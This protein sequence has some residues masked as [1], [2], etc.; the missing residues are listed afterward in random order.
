MSFIF[1]EE[2]QFILDH[3][4]DPMQV[5]AGAGSGKTRVL[6]ERYY[7]LLWQGVRVNNILAVTFTRKAA[8]EMVDRIRKRII[9]DEKLRPEVKD[10]LQEEL[11]FAFIGTIHS[12]CARL[13]RENP[14]E[15]GVDPH[16]RLIDEVEAYKLKM[17]I[18][19][20]SVYEMLEKNNPYLRKYVKFFGIKGLLDDLYNFLAATSSRGVKIEEL[21]L[22]T[23]M[24][25]T[26]TKNRLPDLVEKMEK[27]L[28]DMKRAAEQLKQGAATRNKIENLA[29]V[30]PQYLP[31]LDRIKT[32][33]GYDA[34]VYAACEKL[35]EYRLDARGNVKESVNSF[36]ESLSELKATLWE[37]KYFP[38]IEKVFLPLALEIRNQIVEEK[39][40]RNLLEF[41]DLEEKT[42]SMLLN[43]PDILEKYRKQF[44]F[45]MVDEFQDT[46]YRQT[47]IFRLLSDDFKRNI[48]TVGDPKQSIYRFRGA[49]VELFGRVGEKMGES[50]INAGL[51]RNYRTLSP[52][53]EFINHFFGIVM[54]DEKIPF[55]PLLPER[56]FTD[57]RRTMVYLT[58]ICD[59]KKMKKE[60]I[61]PYLI[62]RIIHNITNDKSLL[63][64][65]EKSGVMRNISYGDITLLFRTTA[66]MHIFARIFK[67]YGI[68]CHVVGSRDFFIAEE[69]EAMLKL[70]QAV[71]DREDEIAL[72]GAL[73]SFFFRVEN[74][75]LWL[76]KNRGQGLTLRESLQ[77]IEGLPLNEEEKQKLIWAEEVLSWAEKLKNRLAPAEL[78]RLL[79]E[80]TKGAFVPLRYSGTAQK[81]ANINKLVDIAF[82][83]EEKGI[84]S[85]KDFL[86][87]VEEAKNREI[88]EKQA[89]AE[90]EG[91]NRVKL[92]TVHQSKGLE[93]P[94]VIVPELERGF[95]EDDLRQNILVRDED[96]VFLKLSS[97]E[98]SR[99]E[100]K[101]ST[102][103]RAEL[104]EK[105]DSLSEYK[106]LLYVALTRSR[107]LLILTGIGKFRDDGTLSIPG[108]D[109]DPASWLDFLSMTYGDSETGILANDYFE[110]YV[111]DIFDIPQ[112]TKTASGQQPLI[113]PALPIKAVSNKDFI[114]LHFDYLSPTRM[115]E[116]DYCPQSAYLVY[117]EKINLAVLKEEKGLSSTSLGNIVHYLAEKT[118]S[119]ETAE[120][121]TAA[122]EDL[123]EE[124]K[125]EALKL[126]ENYLA[127]EEV[128]AIRENYAYLREVPFLM[129][130]DENCILRGFI[131]GLGIDDRKAC[132]IDL[133]TGQKREVYDVQ[134]AAYGKAVEKIMPGKEITKFIFYLKTG[135][136]VEVRDGSEIESVKTVSLY[137][138]K[139][140]KCT[141]C[142]FKILCFPEKGR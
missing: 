30:F 80:K 8:G 48:F 65:D 77:K 51:N 126:F 103:K 27:S 6:V 16:F 132:I 55:E 3:L 92:M 73:R 40:K 61:Q 136:L 39:E 83:L 26:E 131:D 23:E 15:A 35:G 139:S 11:A 57:G 56:E 71:C 33:P 29:A 141:N 102:R 95:N 90:L 101:Q 47:E 110:I 10:K 123:T 62:T 18:I 2:Q 115:A 108:E 89:S 42:L 50:G 7:R 104:E 13:L 45:I 52:I 81:T 127:N 63:I 17:D 74:E 37:L 70:L 96:G 119:L 125:K 121:I 82:N 69:V 112:L 87:Y 9:E 135:E 106:R 120:K 34:E 114:T 36:R 12:I 84:I 138:E 38:L 122:Y 98:T 116:Y 105:R 129:K 142:W 72:V 41:D 20:R 49:R 58:R 93:F 46:N 94:V 43:N 111:E 44:E 59:D 86:D 97:D 28:E 64:W 1:N 53:I 107:D 79:W 68:P 75:T 19:R 60:E 67:D 21:Q 134:L 117:Q 130:L 109:K 91:E 66:N 25:Y 85:L 133:K 137:P 31:V 140:E 5:S 14:L 24:A 124:D 100:R 118:D 128:R 99:E 113:K 54:A 88:K 76:L 78:I 4:D 22:K 32:N